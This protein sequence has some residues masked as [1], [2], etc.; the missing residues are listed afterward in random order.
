MNHHI[1]TLAKP[2]NYDPKPPKLGPYCQPAAGKSPSTAAPPAPAQWTQQ[3]AGDYIDLYAQSGDRVARICKYGPQSQTPR[4][5]EEHAQLVM[6]AFK[7][8]TEVNPDNPAAV[9]RALPI[10][11]QTLQYIC[12]AHHPNAPEHMPELRGISEEQFEALIV[13]KASLAIA[14]ATAVAGAETANRRT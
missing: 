6:E 8:S 12:R 3:D 7:A 2:G 5:H 1:E 10:M 11:L 9:A 13:A 14:E 4:A